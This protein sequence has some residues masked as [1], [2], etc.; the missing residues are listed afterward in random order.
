MRA[1]REQFAQFAVKRCRSKN[2][3][4]R[5]EFC[6]DFRDSLILDCDLIMAAWR[7]GGPTSDCI[8]LASHG[9]L[10]VAVVELKGRRYSSSR[11]ISQLAAG[12]DLAMDLLDKSG[13]PA[14][15]DLRLILVAPGHTYDQIEA[16]T[17]RRL[18]VRGRR[19]RI[20]PVKCGAQFSRIL[21]SV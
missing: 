16:L 6:A 9:S 4:A 7:L 10:H 19:I 3:R 13:L 14:D 12:A 17:T 8:V 5:C 2:K 1:A 20:Q 18:R 15:T 11:A 21:D